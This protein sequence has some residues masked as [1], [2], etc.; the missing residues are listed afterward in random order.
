[1]SKEV[2]TVYYARSIQIM[3]TKEDR[4]N[5]RAIKE[6]YP[7]A[8]IDKALK[9]DHKKRKGVRDSMKVFH[10]RV[11]KADV[12]ILA[13]S[14]DGYVSSGVMSEAQHALHNRIPVERVRGNAFKKVK[15]LKVV[16]EPDARKKWA[17]V[18][19]R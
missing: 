5:I 8:K 1:M 10:K 11:D 17:K 14:V 19:T 15:D 7:D 16:K 4:E 9:T 6:K 12:V 2:K 13:E 18:K 3:G